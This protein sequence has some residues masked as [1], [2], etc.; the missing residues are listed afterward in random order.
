MQK[1]GRKERKQRNQKKKK[2]DGNSLEGHSPMVRTTA[3]SLPRASVQFLVAELRFHK[4]CSAAKKKKINT[5]N[6]NNLNSLS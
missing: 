2:K 1:A 4:P 5:F 6:V 3:L